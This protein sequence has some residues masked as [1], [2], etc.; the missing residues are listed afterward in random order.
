MFQTARFESRRCLFLFLF[1]GMGVGS[2]WG[3]SA[4]FSGVVVRSV[5]WICVYVS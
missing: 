1:V 2:S 3:W 4:P 5:D